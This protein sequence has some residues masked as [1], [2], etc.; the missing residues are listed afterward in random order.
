MNDLR[1]RERER[2]SET[3]KMLFCLSKS[4]LKFLFTLTP[5]S[6]SI[7]IGSSSDAQEDNL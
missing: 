3:V 4:F 6:E 5:E 2:E 7:E 1:E